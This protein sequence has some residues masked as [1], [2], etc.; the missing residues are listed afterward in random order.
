MHKPEDVNITYIP[1]DFKVSLTLFNLS[2]QRFLQCFI[3]HV[4]FYDSLFPTKVDAYELA[5]RA[6]Q[7]YSFERK[8]FSQ[9][10]ERPFDMSEEA[11]DQSIQLIRAIAQISVQKDQSIKKK[12]KK[13][14]HKVQKLFNLLNPNTVKATTLYLYEDQSLRLSPDFCMLCETHRISPIEHLTNVMEQISEADLEARMGL[15][16]EV[17]N[18]ALAFYLKVRDG[19]GNIFND[20][21]IK[22]ITL[23]YLDELQRMRLSLFIYRSVEERTEKHRE[24]LDKYYDLLTA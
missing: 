2:I 22:P 10:Q 14:K 9:K 19:Y 18:P 21:F 23:D 15:G 13:A 17:E 11:R 4:S 16:K 8:E 3:D 12:R 6:L 5:T 24:F 1:H 20:E 7:K